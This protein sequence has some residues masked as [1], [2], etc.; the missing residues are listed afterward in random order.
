MPV[1]LVANQGPCGFP[2]PAVGRCLCQS[3]AQAGQRAGLFTCPTPSRSAYK[4]LRRQMHDQKKTA[5]VAHSI[6][7]RRRFGTASI[8]ARESPCL[9][10]H[11]KAS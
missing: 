4:S 2:A 11:A 5:M 6:P 9:N 3:A 7:S 1:E 8:V 10:Y